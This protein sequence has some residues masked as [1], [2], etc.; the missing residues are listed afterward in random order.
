MKKKGLKKTYMILLLFLSIIIVSLI[1]LKPVF[2]E[3]YPCEYHPADRNMDNKIN[4]TEVA[5]YNFCWKTPGCTTYGASISLSF[6]SNA[7]FIWKSRADS[8]YYCNT[9]I[10]KPGLWKSGVL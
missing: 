4:N 9:S 10:P 1:S 5:S 6:N 7:N 8:S 3:T 2:A